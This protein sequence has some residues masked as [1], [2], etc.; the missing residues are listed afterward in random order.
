MSTVDLLMCTLKGYVCVRKATF[1]AEFKGYIGRQVIY[2]VIYSEHAVHFAQARHQINREM[3]QPI[4]VASKKVT[5]V[6]KKG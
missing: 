6:T 2:S 1:H 3:Q 5:T 4:I